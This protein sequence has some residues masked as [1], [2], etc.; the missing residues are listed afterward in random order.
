M[1]LSTF[2]GYGIH[3]SFI[4]AF[5][6]LLIFLENGM[7]LGLGLFRVRND[8]IDSI[9]AFTG[10]SDKVYTLAYKLHI[11]IRITLFTI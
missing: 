7:G 10:V 8:S 2:C 5:K 9:I 4:G 3:N 6:I 11:Y 1:H